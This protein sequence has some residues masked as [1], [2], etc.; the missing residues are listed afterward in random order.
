M[1][2][3]VFSMYYTLICSHL[4]GLLKNFVKYLEITTNLDYSELLRQYLCI[5]KLVEE[6]DSELSILMFTSSLC[7]ASI[8]YFCVSSLLHPQLYKG[9]AGTAALLA[10]WILFVSY[11][12]AFITM[13]VIGSW[14][15]EAS[16]S[17]WIKTQ[18]LIN[19]RHRISFCQSRFLSVVE[20]DFAMTVWKIAPVKR[21]FILA[22]L[23]T[24]FTYCIVLDP[25]FL[26]PSQ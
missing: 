14:I 24:I 18:E 21:S 6:T 5:R 10:E 1:P 23:G 22:A 19:T 25:F 12:L 20:K 2:I 7:Y 3:N 11:C 8:M 17:I 15:H 4:H 13:T 16:A 26:N 9:Y